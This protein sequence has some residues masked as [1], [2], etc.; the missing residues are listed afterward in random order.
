MVKKHEINV[1]KNPCMTPHF[2]KEITTPIFSKNH[3]ILEL[4]YVNSPSPLGYWLD[5]LIYSPPT[6]SKLIRTFIKK[7]CLLS[8]CNLKAI[9]CCN[10]NQYFYH[11]YSQLWI[12]FFQFQCFLE[13]DSIRMIVY[14][15]LNNLSMIEC[16]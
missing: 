10:L 7:F 11:D 16:D 4:R 15:Q 3:E 2:N 8:C 9:C 5:I 12:V 6:L 1:L 14:L 13:Y